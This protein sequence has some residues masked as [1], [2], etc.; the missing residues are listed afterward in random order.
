[1]ANKKS[2]AKRAR[3]TIVRTARNRAVKSTVRTQVRKFR[4][5]TAAKELSTEAVE[6]E[7][8]AAAA[9]LSKAA[10]KGVLHKRN[11]SRRISRLAKAANKAKAAATAQ[12]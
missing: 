6:N 8:R 11:A 9:Q 12:A 1:M 3:Q 2:A 10:S 4:E 7:F 5:A